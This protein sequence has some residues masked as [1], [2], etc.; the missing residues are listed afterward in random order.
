MRITNTHIYFFSKKDI[1]SNFAETPFTYTIEIDD[2]LGKRVDEFELNC[3]E[4]A[5]MYEKCLFFNQIELANKCIVTTNP[6]KVKSIG[7]SIP[8]FDASE[9]SKVSFDYMYKVCLQKFSNNKEA[10]QALLNSKDKILCEGSP[11]DNI[12]GCG[13]YVW[14]D[15]ILNE[16]NWTG[17]N[18]LGKVLMKVRGELFQQKS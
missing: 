10:K 1:F 11:Y 15:Y 4:Q 12:W 9:W 2:M 6:K 5:Y 14:D 16:N 8:N 17:E 18:R 3:S 13:F 7:I